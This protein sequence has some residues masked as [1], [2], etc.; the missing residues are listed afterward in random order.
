MSETNQTTTGPSELPTAPA[1]SPGPG[2]AARTWPVLLGVVLGAVVLSVLIALVAKCHLCHKYLTSYQH[3]RLP[4][5]RK[6]ICP[7]MGEDEDDDGFIEDNY[8]QP[9]AGGLGTE[10]SRTHFSL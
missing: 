3:R 4:E 1:V 10:G 5:T 8:I 9:G 7:E 2:A 6:G